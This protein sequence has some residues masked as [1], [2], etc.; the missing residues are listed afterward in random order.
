LASR[1]INA[2]VMTEESLRTVFQIMDSEASYRIQIITLESI[3]VFEEALGKRGIAYTKQFTSNASPS[4]HPVLLIRDSEVRISSEGRY[5]LYSNI[6][7]REFIQVVFRPS[8]EEKAECVGDAFLARSYAYKNIAE[9][10]AMKEDRALSIA[11][12]HSSCLDY[13]ESVVIFVMVS[14]HKFHDILE[15]VGE[16][17]SELR[18]SFLLQL[19]LNGLVQKLFV[20]RSGDR[21]RINVSMEAVRAIC[22]RIGLNVNMHQR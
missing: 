2:L 16:I 9:L 12:H 7:Q 15:G 11:E 21:Y 14:K 22:L 1:G 10:K 3:E 8:L 4:P 17:C 13:Y 20:L 18:N 5:I 6:R 19:K